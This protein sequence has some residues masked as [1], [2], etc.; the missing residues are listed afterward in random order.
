M[1][2]FGPLGGVARRLRRWRARRYWERRWRQPDYAPAWRGRDVSREI[3]AAVNDGWFA[4]G[5]RALD[6]GC[7]EGEVVSWLAEQGFPVVGIDISA[8]AV[9]RARKRYGETPGRLEFRQLDVC[10]RDPTGGPFSVLV[11]RGCFHTIADRDV[12]EYARRVGTASRSGAR[13]LLFVKAFRQGGE[14]GQPEERAR[15]VARIESAL[16]RH[17]VLERVAETYL[18][19]HGGAQPD[20]ALPGLV[21]WLT[22]R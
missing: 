5:S 13:L 21:F 4:R 9:A 1:G 8:A 6:I 17:F 7:G 2:R 14:F 12:A 11:D 16:S 3:V 20:A 18:D 15:L 10:A 22:R 19:P